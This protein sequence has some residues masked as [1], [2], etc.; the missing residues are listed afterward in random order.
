MAHSSQIVVWLCLSVGQYLLV[1]IGT[2][3]ENQLDK[4]HTF[5]T[6]DDGKKWTYECGKMNNP[7]VVYLPNEWSMLVDVHYKHGQ[8]KGKYDGLLTLA[9]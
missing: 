3:H 5:G 7:I 6:N 9:I 8:M 4:W 2:F 1:R